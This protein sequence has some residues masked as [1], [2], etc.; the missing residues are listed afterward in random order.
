MCE[1]IE[2]VVRNTDESNEVIRNEKLLN[3]VDE[4]NTTWGKLDWKEEEQ[5]HVVVG[6][7]AVEKLYLNHH[8]L[9][10]WRYIVYIC[11]LIKPISVK[12]GNTVYKNKYLKI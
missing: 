5:R 8:F 12:I 10:T 2:L 1:I 4:L 9:S 3:L 11:L 7:D 6:E